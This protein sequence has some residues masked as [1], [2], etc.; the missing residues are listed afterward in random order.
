MKLSVFK[1]AAI[2]ATAFL[3]ANPAFAGSQDFS[4]VN[5][6]G[7]NLKHIY[8]SESNNDNWDED[9][10]GR[11]LLNDG[12]ELEVSFDRDENTCKWD[13][14]VIYEDSESAIW[15]GLNLCQVSKV[16]LRWNKSTGVTSAKV[17]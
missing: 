14:K 9:I 3:F 10:L 15:N 4:I 8:V 1:A 12:E 2:A 13:L 6:T 7:Y 5:A 17:E 11:D 16:T